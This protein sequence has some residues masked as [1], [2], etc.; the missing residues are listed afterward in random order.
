MKLLNKDNNSI[1][2]ITDKARIEKLLGYPDRFEKIEETKKE[3]KPAKVD[4]PKKETK[5]KK[6]E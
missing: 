3:S 5:N 1:I 4:E 6:E 2:E